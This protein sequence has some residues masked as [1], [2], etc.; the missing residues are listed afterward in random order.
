MKRSIP[1]IIANKILDN[2][3]NQPLNNLFFHALL[4]AIAIFASMAVIFPHQ[5]STLVQEVLGWKNGAIVKTLF[6]FVL[7]FNFTKIAQLGMKA[8]KNLP[9]AQKVETAGT[10]EGIPTV[11][12]LDH[13][14]Q[15]KSFKR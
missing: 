3:E 15:H 1:N 13:L 7:T 12:L 8:W 11:E 14:F 6:I 4:L 9:E 5:I 10:L 2:I